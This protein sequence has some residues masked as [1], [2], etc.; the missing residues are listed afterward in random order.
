MMFFQNSAK[1]F[2]IV[3]ESFVFFKTNSY[4]AAMG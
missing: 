1:A 2:K 4:A 3:T